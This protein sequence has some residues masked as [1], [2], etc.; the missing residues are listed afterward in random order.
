MFNFIFPKEVLGF[1]EGFLFLITFQI[2]SDKT[3]N[4]KVE[5]RRAIHDQVGHLPE[6]ANPDTAYAQSVLLL[7]YIFLYFKRTVV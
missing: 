3:C 7:L 1:Y 4:G 6:L 2:S 5:K